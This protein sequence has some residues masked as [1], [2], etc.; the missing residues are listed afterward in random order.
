MDIVANN[1][2]NA[3][4]PAYKAE[5]MVFQEY[6]AK[7]T[8]DEKLSF[9]QDIGTARDLSSGPLTTTG[10]DFDIALSDEGYF[11]VDTPLGERYTRHGRFQLDSNGQMVTGIGNPVQGQAGP[12]IIPEN[13]GRISI[14]GDGTVSNDTGV[15]GKLQVVTFEDEQQL[16]KAANGLFSAPPDLPPQALAQ[17]SMVQGMIEDSNVQPVL[18]LTRMMD[19]N[20]MHESVTNFIQR[21]D[22]RMKDMIDKLGRVPQG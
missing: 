22:D 15:L 18:E 4:T 16:R 10:N 12:I 9:V 20:R 1:I 3:N 2:A 5:R 11:V 7:P 8:K 17:P 6:L 14:A 21:E 13:S 19:I